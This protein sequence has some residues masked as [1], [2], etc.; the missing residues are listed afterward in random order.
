MKKSIFALAMLAAGSVHALEVIPSVV[1][2]PADNPMSMAKVELGKQL[3]FDPR[4]SIDG[5]VSCNSCH[6]VMAGGADDRPTSVGVNGQRGGR[7]AP[8]VWNAALL[9][10]QFWDG[11]AATLEDQAK[12][13]P[14]NPIEMGMPSEQAVEER[15]SS[16]PGYKIQFEAVFGEVSY[17]NMA[18][19]IAAYERTLITINSPFDRHMNGDKMAMSE[20]AIKGMQR[21]EE[22][23]CVSCHSGINFAG[24]QM[25]LGEG[26]YQKFPLFENDD[27]AKYNLDEDKGRYEVTK[28]AADMNSWRVPSL[29]N[30]AVTAPYFHNGAVK[31]LH[32]SVR[33]MAVSQ[34]GVELKESEVDEIVAF[35]SSLTGEFP[36]QTM[37]RLPGIAGESLVGSIK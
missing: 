3:Y 6:N 1:Q 27:I 28:D 4:L 9:S 29:R 11:R 26:F 14:L 19:A 37:P 20:Q 36:E 13:P 23:G 18:K 22:L 15:L 24:P 31:T 35:L 7:N 33:I 10:V 30:I 25:T 32:E 2:V 34:L 12:G 5:T 8:T 21:F 17:D 16:I